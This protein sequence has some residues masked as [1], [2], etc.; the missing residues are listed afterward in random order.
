MQSM[1]KQSANMGQRS[2]NNDH[3]SMNNRDF[4]FNGMGNQADFSQKQHSK[5]MRNMAK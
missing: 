1:N 5:N 4:E 3:D 2:P